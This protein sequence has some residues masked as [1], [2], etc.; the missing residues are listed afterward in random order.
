ME[1]LRPL[2]SS[3]V[4]SVTITV[5]FSAAL[6]KNISIENISIQSQLNNVP[7]PE[8]K[9]ISITDT[10]VKI[11]CQPLTQLAS[12][13]VY[14]NNTQSVRFTSIN[15]DATIIDDG[16]SNRILIL[17]PIPSNNPLKTF[18]DLYLKDNIY[19]LSDGTVVSMF[20]NLLSTVN[21]KVLYD[22]RQVK[23]EAYLS[24]LIKDEQKTKTNNP[25]ERLTEES[26]YEIVRVGK[27]K[28]GTNAN[29]KFNIT[30]FT[31]S[32]ITLQKNN[33]SDTLLQGTTNTKGYFNKIDLI[34]NLNKSPVTKITSIVFTLQTGNPI[35]TYDLDRLGYQILDSRYDSSRA[36][37]YLLL[38]DSQI[39]LNDEILSDPLFD[40]TKILNIQV[41]YEYKVLGRYVDATTVSVTDTKNAQREV[42]QPLLNIVN[43]KHAPIVDSNG[44]IPSLG[45]LT[46]SD[47]NNL[48]TAKHPAFITE[49]QYRLTEPPSKPGQYSVDYES[50]TIYVFGADTNATGTGDYPPVVTYK[51]KY[52]YTSEVDYSYDSSLLELVSL[53]LGNLRNNSGV[54]SFN[55][56]EVLTPNVDYVANLHKEELSER[57]ENRLVAL[58]CVKATKA[59]ITN[60]FRIYNETSGEIYTIE[61]FY[62]D[63]IY[64]QYIIPPNLKSLTNERASFKTIPNETL[65]INTE[66][67]NT[68]SLRVL[69][70]NLLNNTI[71]SSS[72]DSIASFKNTSMSFLRNDIFVSEKYYDRY[73]DY[74]FNINKLTTV[75]QYVV[76]YSNGIIY[77]AVNTN[78]DSELGSVLY[79][80]NQLTTQNDHIISVED[81]YYRISV[82]TDKS[83]KFSYSSFSDTDVIINSL[84]YSDEQYLNNSD[85]LYYSLFL[86]NV[87]VW[88]SV[89]FIEGVSY[90]IKSIRGLYEYSDYQN[91]TNPFNFANSSSYSQNQITVNTAIKSYLGSI[92]FDGSDYY[93]ML[94]E[95]IP[96]L[97]ANINY[98]FSVIRLSDSQE[99]WNLS[100]TVTP[101]GSVKLTLPGIGSPVVNQSV[102]ITY[103]I[104][105]N[106]S[107]R[108][109]VDYNKGDLYIDYTYLFDEILIS[110]EYGE[111]V[112]D[113]RQSN[114]IAFNENYY[115]S[116]RVGALRDGLERNFGKLVNIPELA[117]VDLSL[118]RERYRDA[119]YAALSSFPQGPTVEAI[120]NIGRVI[121]HIT[122]ELEESLFNN[123]NLG[124]SLLFKSP[125]ETTG[126]F[127]L[128]PARYDNGIM[129]NKPG[130]S[131]TMP[132][133]SN[134]RFEEGTFETWI[135][136]Q[137]YGIDNDASLTFTIL[138]NNIP[139]S[140]V[141]VFVGAIEDHATL[142]NGVFT[143]SKRDL[144]IGT[145]NKNKDGIFIYYDLDSTGSYYRWYVSI[146]DGYVNSSTF[147]YSIVI[148]TT[149]KMY[150]TKTLTLP[151][152][153]N[154][155]LITKQDS[156][157]I[158]VSSSTQ[159]DETITFVSDNEHYVVDFGES[160]DRNRFSIYKDVS[161]YLN[162]RIIDRHGR[163]FSLSHNVSSWKPGENH[164]ISTTWK[165]NTVDKKD[166]MHLFIDGLEVP[167]II[168][169]SQKTSVYL[170]DK[171]RSISNE[172]IL[173]LAS[174]DIVGSID[175]VTT[176]GSNIVSSLINF[177]GHNISPGDL[178][179]IDEDGFNPAGYSIS[180]ISG[181]NLTLAT[182][183]PLTIT[184]GKFS[185]NKTAF[186]VTSEVNAYKN[187]S[188]SKLQVVLTSNDLVTNSTST[189]TSTVNFISNNIEPGFLIRIDNPAFD[190]TYVIEQV[191]TN[192]LV[193]NADMPVSLSSLSFYIY[194]NVEEELN[195]IRSDNPYYNISINNGVDVLTITNGVNE[196]ELILVKTL[197]LNNRRLTHD[198]Y[199]WGENSESVI[200]GLL[201]SPITL[202]T[203]S[204]KKVLLKS[205]VIGPSNSTLNLG[206]FTSNLLSTS[207][208]T[209]TSLGRYLD[210]TIAG[211]NI[212]FSTNVSVTINGNTTEVITF[213]EAGTKSSTNLFTSI[214][215]IQVVC[216][217]VVVTKNCLTIEVKE[218]TKINATDTSVDAPVLRY[219]YEIESGTQLSGTG[220]LITDTT[221]DFSDAVIG[222]Y[223]H[224]TSPLVVSGY[225]LIQSVSLDRHSL[226]I[227][228]TTPLTSFS[229]GS[230]YIYNVLSGNS[231]FQN[232]Y[233]MLESNP[234]EPFLLNSGTYRIDYY[235]NIQINVDPI[236]YTMYIGTDLNKRDI[237]NA[238]IDELKI[239]SIALTDTRVGENIPSTQ[240]SITK[241]Y[242]AVKPVAL[243]SYVLAYLSFD[244]L[245]LVNLASIY[246]GFDIKN[247]VQSNVVINSLFG[248][249]LYIKNNP[250]VMDNNGIVDYTKEGTIEFWTMPT[251]DTFNDPNNRYYFDGYGAVTEELV[252]S[253][254]VT[255]PL[256]N[257]A[258]KILSVKLKDHDEEYF[259]GGRIDY[260][261]DNV[262]SEPTISDNT[263][264]VIVENDIFQVISVRVVGDLSGKD[265][266]VGGTI[267]PDRKKIFLGTSLP[268]SSM[269]VI[270]Q[271]KPLVGNGNTFNKQVI[272]LNKRLPIHNT[273]VMVK[274][275][276]SGFR[277]D[278]ISIF[279]DHDGYMNFSIIGN[280]V[281]HVIKAPIVWSN[282][283]WHKVCASYKI[284]SRN[285]DEMRLFIDGYQPVKI[286]A[287]N[288]LFR[289]PINSF[290]IGGD[291]NAKSAINSLID[292]YKISV[293]SKP[294]FLPF[295][296]AVDISYNSNMSVVKPLVEDLYTTLLLNSDF[297]K[298]LNDSFA[299]LISKSGG[300]F[301]FYLKV[302]DSFGI[303]KS[304]D[305]VKELLEILVKQ[306][307]PASS[308]V[309]I[310]YAS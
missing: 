304:S 309:F 243:N 100:G 96:Y 177:S 34:L 256:T 252:S 160:L 60:V 85:T 271:Y 48:S 72:E 258:S 301:D 299:T 250:I 288:I 49:I 207:Q 124:Q 137:W 306:L 91:S 210:I 278:R 9:K 277:G 118:N 172:E 148:N 82:L 214:T 89:S 272:R 6:N 21:S 302:F 80:N 276:P 289:D 297:E 88:D 163:R 22:I 56:E 234:G 237:V 58:N 64:F 164:F 7:N 189:V 286:T 97:S 81:I 156:F 223:I 195:G 17:G 182:S 99:L 158:K 44:T 295:G 20:L 168:K 290:V 166:E 218:K 253:D 199:V 157:T 203:T 33:F 280:G 303:V 115:V 236:N 173:G 196:D 126:E 106:D 266:F 43:L 265:Y 98:S 104:S 136:P 47:V 260:I 220:Y 224:I 92:Q 38:N 257:N 16:I 209:E 186:N 83:K 70:I 279:K 120:K 255:I 128:I 36:F 221:K 261:T 187:I 291:Y 90:P 50:G 134:F 87:G 77:I 29:L 197:G 241:D 24:L 42:L 132:V 268:Q 230:Y 294:L 79:K 129:V 192:S 41:S 226:T 174:A 225:Y 27:T 178:I 208:P 14:F 262:I 188:V 269:N 1:N 153:S 123:W 57:V 247:N 175:L 198:Y 259:V 101:G 46:I 171:F 112:I 68:S 152:P 281:D 139:V 140:D 15:G 200:R 180:S 19:D 35:Y 165:L 162:F 155:Q 73:Q 32:P 23:N 141:D 71:S 212:D 119:L 62:E 211:T 273:N 227:S 154:L 103:N 131:I 12:Y 108:V 310:S 45:G 300:S 67:T 138:R 228:S 151:K 8:V 95:N 244:T 122:P 206:V 39:K 285:N 202:D 183:M 69:K 296:E 275:L 308:R 146:I 75:G 2:N 233:F 143:I 74:L 63:K 263:S 18:A 213:S 298:E 114:A 4:D 205:T 239:Y 102:K 184:N 242:N 159:I 149:G 130:Q 170:H 86:G 37:N 25:F 125:I 249:S 217:P 51:Y 229:G 248:N 3:V 181:Q 251:Y 93:V 219:S 307:K 167:N 185:V 215:D 121:S 54:I 287:R 176:L 52:T 254:N 193:L 305:K 55:Y 150:D 117:N 201:P 26:A 59:P 135:V 216:K 113:F 238:I 28:T 66:Y 179:F 11:T 84:N 284:N 246:K 5:Q 133:V 13:Y 105:I 245:P 191:N 222:N 282:N 190:T 111:N 264:L 109:V 61:R 110:Y 283:T 267:S 127:E 94:P 161:G 204:I 145:P 240:R 144:I 232:G 31:S 293:K 235:S 78:Q 292:S 231:G 107:S 274:Y 53:P 30:E 76:D 169:Y 147:T 142:N 270:V 40:I 65:Y 116:Y 194:S 10:T